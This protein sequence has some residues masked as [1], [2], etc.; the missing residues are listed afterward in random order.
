[1]SRKLYYIIY[2][3]TNLINGKI[4][5]G[6]TTQKL[7][8]RWASHRSG[9][10]AQKNKHLKL[11]KAFAKYGIDNFTIKSIYEATSFEELRMKENEFILSTKSYLDEYGYNMSIDTDKGL[12]LLDEESIGRKLNSLH[13]AQAKRGIG[14]WGVGIRR[15]HDRFYANIRRDGIN[16][17]LGFDTLEEAKESYDKLAIHLYGTDAIL[18]NPDKVYSQK[19][20]LTNYEGHKTVLNRGYSSNLWGVFSKRPSQYLASISK[21]K[22]MYYLGTFKTEREAAMAVDRARFVLYGVEAKKFNFPELLTTY[23]R[24]ESLAW[25]NTIGE[26]RMRGLNWDKRIQRYGVTVRTANKTLGLG[27]YEDP[28]K[29]AMIR[30]MAVFH[31]GL[32]GPLNYPERVTWYKHENQYKTITERI[33]SGKTKYGRGEIEIKIPS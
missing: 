29:A 9:V 4:Y 17:C 33:L 11:Y 25:F 27:S 21:D 26:N 5:I 2:Q 28:A 8:L 20:I 19:D 24:E 14:K 1:M 18:N 30:D 10:K 13:H 16:Y 12:A 32:S 22:H 15:Y 3:I 31:L 7:E 23:D 6:R